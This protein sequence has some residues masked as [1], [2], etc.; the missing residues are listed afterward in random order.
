MKRTW[1]LSWG[2]PAL[3]LFA[4]VPLVRLGFST[5]PAIDPGL[6]PATWAQPVTLEGVPNLYRVDANLYRSAQPTEQG[7]RNLRAMGIRHVISLRRFHSDRSGL[8]GSGLLEDEL[9]LNTWHI[10]TEDVVRVL[11]TLKD[12]S[13]GP[14]LIHCQHGADRTGVMCAM[15]R[16][17]IQGWPREEAIRELRDGGFGFHPLWRNI[18]L[19]L[20]KVDIAEIRR[21]A[22]VSTPAASL[23]ATAGGARR[24]R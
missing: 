24:D 2:M 5:S 13:G 8:L 14:Y 18:L 15:Y 19:Y 12:T 7:L 21:R 22:G 17:V 6:R 23:A 4:V 11:A 3:V 16:I 10:E 1:W 9:R 20:K